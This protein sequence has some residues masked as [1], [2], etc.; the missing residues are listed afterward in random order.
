MV[1]LPLFVSVFGM[2]VRGEMAQQDQT[3][4]VSVGADSDTELTVGRLF[5]EMLGVADLPRKT[6]LFDLGL[7]SLSVT[8]ACAR[9]EQV[10]GVRIRFSQLFRTPT[11]AQLAAWIDASLGPSGDPGVSVEPSADR[12]VELVAVTPMQAETVPMGIVVEVAWWFDGEI[13]VAALES[14]AGDVHRRHQALRARYLSG[15]DLG[16][17]EVPIDPGQAEFHRLGQVDDEA[18]A[19]DVLQRTLRQPLRLGEGEVWRCAIVRSGQS[20][21]TLFGFAV[22]HA[23][24]D[25]RSW[26]ILTAELPVAYDARVAGTSPQWSGRTASLAEM[27]A[28]AR[29]QSK[30][31][32]ADAQRRYWRDELRELPACDLPGRQE[33]PSSAGARWSA[34]GPAAVSS[35]RVENAQ[36]TVWNDYA[37]AMGMSPSVGIAAAYVQA[38]I[39]AGGTRDFALMVPIG[40]RAGEVIDRTITN[41]VCDIVLR[42]NS[43]FRSGS[44]IL[45]RM[46]DSYHQAMAA[47]DVL[48]DPKELGSILSGEDSDGK[49]RLDRMVNMNY[50]SLPMLNLGDVAGTIVPEPSSETRCAFFVMLLVVPDPDGLDMNIIA[51]TDMYEP[52]LA[53]RLRRHFLDIITE[54]PEQLE[55]ETTD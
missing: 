38:I 45:T 35:F 2:V 40:N 37:R 11:V 18:A 16:L 23:A 27:A 55:L 12:A 32:D 21:R 17:A 54:G 4:I 42:P 8:V 14:A 31:A 46:R 22:D 53:D 41:R 3:V 29:H 33:V 9:L 7:D 50:N 1:V 26:D 49:I 24:F 36:L 19:I 6:S 10:T 25:G 47:R 52:G 15:P 28:D 5:A 34:A 48:V 30:S 13:E 20:G 39:R 51:R 43:P 44:N